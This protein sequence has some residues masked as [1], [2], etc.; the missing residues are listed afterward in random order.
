M[1]RYKA[2][3]EYDGTDFIG[4]QRQVQE[5]TI[6]GELESALRRINEG[7][8]VSISGAGRTDTG[9]HASGQV[10]AF[11]LEWRHDEA[12]LIKAINFNLPRSIAVRQIA[13]CDPK[14]H[15]RFDAR[16]RRYRYT[17]YN[18][19]MRSPL[20]ERFAWWVPESLN[21]K[22]MRQASDIL[23]GR[24]DFATFGSAPDE[25][26]HTMREVREA[27]WEIVENEQLLHFYIGADAFLYR[28]VRSIVG[29]LK[30]V[31]SG[32][33]SLA[34]FEE[35]ARAADRSRSG[36]IAPPN[37]LCLIEVIY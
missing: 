24:K 23:I 5:P 15:P 3:L 13:G 9:V 35:A 26:G 33:M 22:A 20:R 18:A 10:V 25:G 32:E 29:A 14:F 28:M 31:G 17:I 4:F 1:A 8:P 27:R 2:V 19:G 11:N 7:S 16:G 34:E 6:Q 37:G 36:K 30:R 21:V 12:T